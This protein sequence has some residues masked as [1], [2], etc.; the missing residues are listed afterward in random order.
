MKK[1]AKKVKRARRGGAPKLT[2]VQVKAALKRVKQG[3]TFRAVASDFGVHST[4]IQY[5]AKKAG[6]ESKRARA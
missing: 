1:K 3:E 4:A 2:P 6:I 5:Q